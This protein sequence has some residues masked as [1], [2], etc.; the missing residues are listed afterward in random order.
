MPQYPIDVQYSSHTFEFRSKLPKLDMPPYPVADV[1]TVDG[2]SPDVF[3]DGEHVALSNGQLV[4]LTAANLGNFTMDQVYVTHGQPG[5]ADHAVARSRPIVMDEPFRA[6]TRLIDQG[7]VG[8]YAE[9]T[10]LRI[11]MVAFPK[12]DTAGLVPALAGQEYIATVTGPAVT[13]T[14]GNVWIPVIYRKGIRAA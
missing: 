4:R 1:S 6:E 7:N 13:G 2:G 5:R 8:N 14:D 10:R 3:V 12:A 11:G 9:G